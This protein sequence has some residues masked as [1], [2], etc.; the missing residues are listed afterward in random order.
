M[1]YDSLHVLVLMLCVNHLHPSSLKGQVNLVPEQDTAVRKWG[2]S[3]WCPGVLPSVSRIT[4]TAQ[5][6]RLFNSEAFMEILNLLQGRVA[7]GFLLLGGAALTYEQRLLAFQ[8]LY[9][10]QFMTL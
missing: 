9:P 6:V 4:L 7:K 1:R 3:E 10:N 8:H 2:Y 5:E